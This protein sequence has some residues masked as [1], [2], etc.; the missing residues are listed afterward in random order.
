MWR[1]QSRGMEG[2]REGGRKGGREKG[3]ARKAIKHLMNVSIN[4]RKP[5][6]CQSLNSSSFC[7]PPLPPSLSSCAQGWEGVGDERQCI[8]AFL[9]TWPQGKMLAARP[10]KCPKVGGADYAI[11]DNPSLALKFGCV[12]PS[13][14]PSPHPSLPPYI[15]TSLPP[16][17]PTSLPPYIPTP[18]PPSF[19]LFLGPT[20]VMGGG[21][22]PS[23]PSSLPSLPPSLPL[24]LPATK[25]SS[26]S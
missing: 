8:S 11:D 19:P 4:K 6:M 20:S 13:L 16:Y 17:I 12:P 14:P 22:S 25:I 18:L 26:S 21:S 15:P 5:S 1:L 3:R 24:S 23:F 2:G 10:I 7:P 9:F